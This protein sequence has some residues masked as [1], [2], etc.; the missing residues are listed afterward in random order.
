MALPSLYER[1]EAWHR[2]RSRCPCVESGTHPCKHCRREIGDLVALL[3]QVAGDAILATLRATDQV[4]AFTRSELR[5]GA[6]EDA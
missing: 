4:L 1:A 3:D 2:R 6:H 5:S